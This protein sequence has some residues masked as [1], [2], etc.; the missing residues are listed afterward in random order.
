MMK[1]APTP[2]FARPRFGRLN[3]AMTYSGIGRSRLYELAA[4][5][6]GLFKKNGKA[7]VVDFDLL[8]RVLDRLPA[9]TLKPWM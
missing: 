5:T 2:H 4:A 1:A 8:D 9:A 7:T 6:P 3:A